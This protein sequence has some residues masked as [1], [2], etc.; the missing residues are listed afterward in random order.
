[1]LTHTTLCYTNNMKRQATLPR[2]DEDWFTV[3]EIAAIVDQKTEQV[4]KSIHAAREKLRHS[5]PVN[6]P[7]K[8]K[9]LQHTAAH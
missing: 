3:E 1:M 5:F 9:L 6:N 4:E 2:V 7:F 8:N